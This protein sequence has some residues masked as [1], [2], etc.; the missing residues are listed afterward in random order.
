VLFIGLTKIIESA[1]S[2]SGIIISYSSYYRYAVLFTFAYAVMI[3]VLN[4]WLIPILNVTGAALATLMVAFIFNF[5]Y[6]FFVWR[7]SKVQPFQW[8]HVYMLCLLLLGMGVN[9]II[10]KMLNIYVDTVVR[11][12][13]IVGGI[14]VIAYFT[15]ISKE[16]NI[17]IDEGCKRFLRMY[18][19]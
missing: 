18:K 2:M 5:F 3:I 10:P 12:V 19:K 11:T 4:N 13:L 16:A 8:G 7:K 14:A 15:K 17:I 6:A 1:M 9:E